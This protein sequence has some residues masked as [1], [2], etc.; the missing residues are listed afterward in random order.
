MVAQCGW[1][2]EWKLPVEAQH[3]V[4]LFLGC[5]DINSSVKGARF[6][7]FCDSFNI[8]LITFVD[9]PGFLP[10][11]SLTEVGQERWFCPVRCPLYL[12]ILLHSSLRICDV[13]IFWVSGGDPVGRGKPSQ[14]RVGVDPGE[15]LWGSN[16]LLVKQALR[17]SMGASS[18]T[19]PSCSTRLQ[20]PLCPKWRSSPGRWGAQAG[21]WSPLTPS[22]GACGLGVWPRGSAVPE[23]VYASLPL[24]SSQGW[25]SVYGSADMPGS[26]VPA[27]LGTESSSGERPEDH[28][29]ELWEA[30]GC[31][32]VFL[33]LPALGLQ[34]PR[35][36]SSCFSSS[37][38]LASWGLTGTWSGWLRLWHASFGTVLGLWWCLW[39][40]ELQAPLWWHQLRLAHGGDCCHGGKGKTLQGLPSPRI[41]G[42]CW[43]E[44]WAP[45]V[46]RPPGSWGLDLAV[47]LLHFHFRHGPR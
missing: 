2:W 33:G 42:K 34:E 9:V 30:C 20:R 43:E 7:R 28:D 4:S 22:G 32:L 37:F 45:G 44:A 19:A 47:P 6:V 18:A 11:E 40:H 29:H 46:A 25:L 23:G 38:H 1:D 21:G 12:E 3:V 26:E 15:I 5:L 31:A 17:R 41:A 39:C 16:N 27:Y 35:R 14:L 8:P 10:G 24:T 36:A 13:A